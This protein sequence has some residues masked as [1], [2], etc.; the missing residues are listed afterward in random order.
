M[1]D[2]HT[3]TAF[4]GNPNLIKVAKEAQVGQK[5]LKKVGKELQEDGIM[6]PD[7]EHKKTHVWVPRHGAQ[8]LTFGFASQ[9]PG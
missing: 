6:D 4:P 9:Q 8:A 2:K 5:F 7:V 1:Y 3:M